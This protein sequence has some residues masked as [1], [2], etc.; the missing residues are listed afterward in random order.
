M[1]E[2]NATTRTE[3][4]SP[5]ETARWGA[6]YMVGIGGCGMSGLARMLRSLGAS[7]SGSEMTRTAT[8]LY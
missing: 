2:P 5:N 6:V 3:T 8:P 7:V 4:R 1:R